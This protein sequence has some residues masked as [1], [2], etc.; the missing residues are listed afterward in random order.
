MGCG[1]SSPADVQDPATQCTPI[2]AHPIEDAIVIHSPA[3]IHGKTSKWT[4]RTFNGRSS[5][6]SKMQK[7]LEALFE[8]LFSYDYISLG[9]VLDK[10]LRVISGGIPY[11]FVDG[12][13]RHANAIREVVNL[14][15]P[16]G[17]VYEGNFTCIE[18]RTRAIMLLD[19]YAKERRYEDFEEIAFI[20]TI[21]INTP[22][23]LRGQTRW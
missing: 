21:I 19:K 2:I 1:M 3:I 17:P 8:Q 23:I 14:I 12:N 20:L 13:K 18:V 11:R 5:W 9:H 16:T 10:Y 22:N 15:A 4:T 6:K 7:Y